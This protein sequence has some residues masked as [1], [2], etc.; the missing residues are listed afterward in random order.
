MRTLLLLPVLAISTPLLAQK[1]DSTALQFVGAGNIQR[2]LDD[3]E[4]IPASTGLGV[5][6]DEYH[7]TD[8][9]LGNNIWRVYFSGQINVANTE[10]SL[11][12]EYDD[13]GAL[14]NASAFGQS[15][16]TPLVG[17]NAVNLDMR[18]FFTD[19]SGLKLAKKWISGVKL[20]Y[21]ASNR[22]WGDSLQVLKCTVNSWRLGL[23][24]NILDA[25]KYDYGIL[26]GV[27][28][29]YNSVRGDVGLKPNG[30][31]RERLFGTRKDMFWGV[32]GFA[33]FRLKNLRAEFAYT[34]EDVNGEIPGLSGGR[35]VTTIGFVG[36]FSM[37]LK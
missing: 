35:M 33:E 12:A 32:E 3:G 37:K 18:L 19:D 6:L 36:G 4:G 23:F 24:H 17:R 29:A 31:L 26:L 13:D 10:D 30:D 8:P 2:T 14:S 5:V 11:L 16:L 1:S 27:A 28:Y 15:V 22:V 9:I 20:R 34:W 25:D 21:T 7:R